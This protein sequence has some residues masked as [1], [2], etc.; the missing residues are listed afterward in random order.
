LQVLLNA[1]DRASRPFRSVEKAS[2]A[3]SGNIRNTQDTLRKL[4]AQASQ[5]DGFRKASAQ[6]AVTRANLKK[7][8]EEA[9]RLSQAFANTANPTAKQTRLMEAAKRAASELQ[10][11]ENSLRNSVQRQ[12]GALESAG[13]S[14]RNLAAEQRRLRAS[15]QEA[16]ATL[17][18]QREELARL[19]RQQQRRENSRRR[20]P[21][22]PARRRHYPK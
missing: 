21:G 12:R 1:V 15:S 3:L 4:N 9:S 7:A 2:K 18:R 11:K 22:N 13:I 20:F 17:A 6:L 14:T 19:N 8:K 10:A 16:N 5:I